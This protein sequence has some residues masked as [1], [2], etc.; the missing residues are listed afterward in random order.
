VPELLG[1]SCPRRGA[2]TLCFTCTAGCAAG[3]A[4]GGLVAAWLLPLCGW[5]SVFY[6]GGVSPLLVGVLMIFWLP[7][8]LQS[9]AVRRRLA[10][11]AR[12][13]R[14]IEPGAPAG[15]GTEYVVARE[16]RWRAPGGERPRA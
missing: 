10:E 7:E 13:L 15:P 9:L 16:S 12:W 11:A 14:R 1:G 8:S 2:A 3:A 6:F 5:R 4:G